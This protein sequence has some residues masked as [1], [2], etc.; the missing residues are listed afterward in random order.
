[1][2]K[3]ENKKVAAETG[4]IEASDIQ[5]QIQKL[6]DENGLQPKFSFFLESTPKSV[7]DSIELKKTSKGTNWTIKVY[8]ESKEAMQRANELFEECKNKYGDEE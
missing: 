2:N 1:M 5:T 3:R 7:N 6:A 8:G 4:S